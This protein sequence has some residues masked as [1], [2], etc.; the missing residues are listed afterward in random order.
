MRRSFFHL[1]IV[2]IGLLFANFSCEDH[3]VP[4]REAQIKT[5]GNAYVQGGPTLWELRLSFTELGNVPIIEYGVVTATSPI[6]TPSF[7]PTVADSKVIFP[8][9]ATLGLKTRIAIKPVAIIV[10]YRAYAIL[11]NGTIVYGETFSDD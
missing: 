2:F 9:P 10:Y 7:N 6:F 1:A 3:V 11:Q 5:E 8:L 4:V